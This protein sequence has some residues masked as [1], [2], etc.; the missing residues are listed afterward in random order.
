MA[1][2]LRSAS[3]ATLRRPGH[4]A[5]NNELP[6]WAPLLGGFG[7]LGQRPGRP[8]QSVESLR[9]LICWNPFGKLNRSIAPLRK[10]VN[11]FLNTVHKSTLTHR[12]Y[13]ESRGFLR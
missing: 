5:Q 6:W 2:G 11:R 7:G 4:G 9:R 10:G 8:V 3:A 13:S 12:H 1:S